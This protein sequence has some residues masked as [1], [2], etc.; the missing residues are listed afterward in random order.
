M[1]KL[2]VVEADAIAAQRH[3]CN[4]GSELAQSLLLLQANHERNNSAATALT[5]LLRLVEAEGGIHNVGQ[6]LD[7]IEGLLGDIQQLR[8]R[9][10]AAPITRSEV[11]I[12]Q[13]DAQHQRVEVRSKIDQLNYQLASA[14]G[15]AA[16]PGINY[17]PEADLV[18][19]PVLPDVEAAVSFGL[20]NRADLMALRRAAQADGREAIA[21]AKLLMAPLGMGASDSGC[22]LKLLQ[23]CAMSREAE[24]RADQ[25]AI[26]KRQ[27]ERDVENEIRQA[28]DL[29]TTRLTQINLTRLKRD[30]IATQIESSRR[31]REVMPS[32][33]SARTLRLDALAADQD[34]LHDVVEWKLALVKLHQAQG[35]LAIE[36]GWTSSCCCR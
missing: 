18:I 20:A 8:Q 11:E 30:A 7:E 24:A 16:E 1:A 9:G 10:L 15:A 32:P 21:A 26:A 25:I 22:S 29:V 5:L 14:L 3:L 27:L 35:L 13:L 28:A 33:D 17:W 12:Q 6:R 4:D 23:I 31:Q 36:C 19:D 34:L 2:L